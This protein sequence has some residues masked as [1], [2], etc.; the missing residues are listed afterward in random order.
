M[1]SWILELVTLIL[2]ILYAAGTVLT[3]LDTFSL[4]HHRYITPWGQVFFSLGIFIILYPQMRKFFITCS[5][6]VWAIL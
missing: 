5:S 6:W 4:Y 2:V 1:K 3:L